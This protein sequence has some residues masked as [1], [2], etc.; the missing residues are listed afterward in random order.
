M[1]IRKP[2]LKKAKKFT[3]SAPY[4]PWDKDCN[5]GLL[6]PEEYFLLGD[7]FYCGSNLALFVVHKM[8]TG[9]K[10]QN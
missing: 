7:I 4:I 10:D 5:P 1:Q 8:W 6:D 3:A 2:M 9:I